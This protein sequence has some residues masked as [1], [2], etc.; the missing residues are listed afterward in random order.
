MDISLRQVDLTRLEHALT[1][2]LSP[3][4]HDRC[5]D[6]RIAVESSV[7][8]FFDGDHAVR[9]SPRFRR[10]DRTSAR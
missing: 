2:V 10:P 6:W 8:G 9:A 3:L 4:V 1:T 5:D 7:A